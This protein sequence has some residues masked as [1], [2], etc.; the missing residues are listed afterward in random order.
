MCSAHSLTDDLVC[1]FIMCR[2]HTNVFLH[3]C[4]AMQRYNYAERVATC[5]DDY[6][7]S[8]RR[9]GSRG[10]KSGGGKSLDGGASADTGEAFSTGETVG[11]G[12]PR[13]RCVSS[14]SDIR[15]W[16][17][18]LRAS[19]WI[20]MMDRLAWLGVLVFLF[21]PVSCEKIAAWYLSVRRVSVCLLW[22]HHFLPYHHNQHNNSHRVSLAELRSE[23][24]VLA[25]RL[26]HD[27]LRHMRA[28]EAAC[29]AIAAEER[30]GYDKDSESII[31]VISCP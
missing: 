25:Q 19:M 20:G 29:H 7:Q 10:G 26:R 28:L 15:L 11:W 4:L 18:Y 12:C 1:I 31:Y 24:P 23:N 22:T 2:L 30:P 13:V 14:C 3:P 17:Y 6:V 5:I 16:E 21:V 9:G 27:P 8:S